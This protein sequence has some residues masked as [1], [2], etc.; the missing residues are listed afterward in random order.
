MGMTPTRSVNSTARWKTGDPYSCLLVEK[1]NPS[2]AEGK[3]AL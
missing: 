1:S 3:S 2:D